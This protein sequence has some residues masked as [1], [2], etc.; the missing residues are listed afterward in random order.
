MRAD[1]ESSR[2]SLHNDA[3][4]QQVLLKKSKSAGTRHLEHL[5]IHLKIR[6]RKSICIK[7]KSDS[8]ALTLS[9]TTRQEI[10]LSLVFLLSCMYRLSVCREKSYF[11]S[12]EF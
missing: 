3:K 12:H 2:V 8:H 6:R 4:P 7:T 1:E 5:Q 9:D 10:K 11:I